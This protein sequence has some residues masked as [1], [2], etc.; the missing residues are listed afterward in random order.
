MLLAWVHI[1]RCCYSYGFKAVPLKPMQIPAS[2]QTTFLKPTRIASTAWLKPTIIMQI[3]SKPKCTAA[4]IEHQRPA[5]T[6]LP[7]PGSP[8]KR[9]IVPHALAQLRFACSLARMHARHETKTKSK[10]SQSPN[11]GGWT[12]RTSSLNLRYLYMYI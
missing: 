3:H 5:N 2:P 9:D 12:S 1:F 7:P 8:S 4:A 10:R 6:A 11:Y